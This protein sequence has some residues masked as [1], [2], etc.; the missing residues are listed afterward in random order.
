MGLGLGM[1]SD[2]LLKRSGSLDPEQERVRVAIG[3]SSPSVSPGALPSAKELAAAA[4]EWL[5]CLRR[6]LDK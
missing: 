5:K 6:H 1:M 3:R 4:A 2:P